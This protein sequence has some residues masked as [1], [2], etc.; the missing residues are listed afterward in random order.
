LL[1]AS[2][3][4]AAAT[5]NAYRPLARRGRGG[6]AAFAAG[7]PTSEAPLLAF[8]GQAM[9]TAWAAST[10][11]LSTRTGRIALAI[12]LASWAGLAGLAIDARRA[13]TVLDEALSAALG[14]GYR[15][16]VP[17]PVR[18]EARLTVT[19]QALPRL[20]QRR[21]YR[22]ARDIAYAEFGKRNRLDI[23]RSADLPADARAPVLLHVHGG[24]WI[25]GDKEVQGEILLTEMA[26]RGWVGATITYR[27]SPGATWPEHIV[28]VKRAI[29]WTRATIAEHGG[30][31]SF[32]AI[33]GG[34][35]GG[36]LAALCALT[37]GDPEYQ[38][39]FEDADTSVQACVP[40]YGVYDVADLAA[41][42][43]REIVD[44]W[45]RLVVKAPLDSDPALWERASPIARVHAG[46][47][48]MFVVH[49][50]N[51]TLVPVEQARR[52]VEQLGAVST[53]PVAYAELPHAQHAFEVLRSVRGIHTTRAIARFLDVIRARA[54][55][56]G[57][58]AAVRTDDVGALGN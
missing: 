23:W 19:E 48:P 32:I 56:D 43:R 26:R 33:T 31:P 40:L 44:L 17:E 28:D 54:L 5:V 50:R 13:S 12:E 34:S 14:A 42:G 55:P 2:A 39:G 35:A 3:V 10:G 58:G 37:A 29:A 51:D 36:H 47:P 57:S 24:A 4:G 7:W 6:I 52:F 9:G 21:R 15:D 18:G 45:E 41:S 8:A 16:D 27:L 20:G 25:I 30:D 53:Q 38:P 46:A 11:A 1:A 22:T 49:G